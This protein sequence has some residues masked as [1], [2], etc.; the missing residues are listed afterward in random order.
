MSYSFRSKTIALACG[1]GFTLM[2]RLA[3]GLAINL[4]GRSLDGLADAANE[5][6]LVA[7]LL[8]S[9]RLL[10]RIE[11]HFAK[12]GVIRIMETGWVKWLAEIEAQKSVKSRLFKDVLKK[13]A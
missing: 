13:V 4:F 11:A 9:F 1:I 8:A 2:I 12:V 5:I 3:I 6:P 10:E 7:G